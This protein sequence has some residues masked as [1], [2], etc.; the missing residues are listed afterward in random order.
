M[1]PFCLT[2]V[3][4]AGLS[5]GCIMPVEPDRVNAAAITDLALA[6]DRDGATPGSD[7]TKQLVKNAKTNEALVGSPEARLDPKDLAGQEANRQKADAAQAARGTWSLTGSVALDA[8]GGVL[9]LLGVGGVGRW[10][11]A[12]AKAKLDEAIEAQEAAKENLRRLVAGVE[13]FKAAAA[14]DAQALL[15]NAI[16]EKA[17]MPAE[18]LAFDAAVREAKAPPLP[19]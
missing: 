2:A 19:D 9:T 8:I 5:A 4:L 14:P 13:K 7:L 15:L 1:K 12:R 17:S 6:V 11:Q 10:L 16:R 3:L 18:R